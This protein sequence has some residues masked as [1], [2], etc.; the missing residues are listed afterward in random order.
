MT[1]FCSFSP[2]HYYRVIYLHRKSAKNLGHIVSKNEIWNK[3]FHFG[4]QHLLCTESSKKNVWKQIFQIYGCQ[5]DYDGSALEL[6]ISQLD[7]S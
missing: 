5:Q 3:K 1:A 7:C 2:N 6:P 4:E